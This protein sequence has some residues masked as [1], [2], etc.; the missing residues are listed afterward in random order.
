MMARILASTTLATAVATG[1]MAGVFFAFSSFVMPGLRRLPADAAI[2]AMQAIN[3]AALG[4]V[5]LGVLFGTALACVLLGG[6]V[7]A[8]WHVPG[9]AL[10]LAG[11][12]AYLIGAIAVTGVANV[13]RNEALDAIDPATLDAASTWARYVA[14]WTAYNHVRALASTA[15]S[16][17]LVLAFAAA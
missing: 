4:R 15:A 8:T 3:A 1:V 7:I 11:C 12:L 5:F 10:R 13:P 9:S 16:A 2:T 6:A 14:E 17:A